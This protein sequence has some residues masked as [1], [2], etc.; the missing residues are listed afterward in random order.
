MSGLLWLCLLATLFSISLSAEQSERRTWYRP[1]PR[2]NPFTLSGQALVN[3]I[4]RNGEWKVI[5][6]FLFT[7]YFLGTIQSQIGRC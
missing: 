5:R 6:A 1:Q 4:N 2:V 3:H 7:L